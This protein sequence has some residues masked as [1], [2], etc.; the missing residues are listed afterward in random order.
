MDTLNYE[1]LI[2]LLEDFGY[3]SITRINVW[4]HAES[5]TELKL[6][7]FTILKKVVCSTNKLKKSIWSC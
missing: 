3:E 5:L 1:Q 6:E 2:S 7:K 4:Y